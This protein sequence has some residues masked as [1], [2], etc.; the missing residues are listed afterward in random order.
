MKTFQA[1]PWTLVVLSF[2]L[3]AARPNVL[4]AAEPSQ[5]PARPKLYDT[6]ANGTEQIAAALKTAKAENKRLILK[7]GANW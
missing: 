1:F 7:F 2:V 6:S 5:K 4:V 3:A